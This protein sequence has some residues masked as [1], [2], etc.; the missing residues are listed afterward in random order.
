M[1]LSSSRSSSTQTGV[2]KN[3]QKC[4]FGRDEKS[5]HSN[6]NRGRETLILA[7]RI[8]QGWRMEELCCFFHTRMANVL[9][10]AYARAKRFPAQAGIRADVQVDSLLNLGRFREPCRQEA[11]MHERLMA[12]LSPIAYALPACS[13]QGLSTSQPPPPRRTLPTQSKRQNIL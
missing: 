4:E 11:C 1:S 6:V 7:R 9:L 5:S 13:T 3:K 10:I 8:R 12:Q 2:L